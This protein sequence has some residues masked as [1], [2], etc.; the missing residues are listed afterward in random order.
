MKKRILSIALIGIMVFA[1]TACSTELGKWRIT[2][3]TAGDINMTQEDI[4][5]MGL[6]PG[7]VK[8]NKSGSCVVNLLGDE[9]EGTWELK[10]DGS[11]SIKYG[12]DLEGSATIEDGV[13]TMTDAQ[14]AVYTLSR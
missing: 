5:D 13:M 6:D 14:G 9:Y 1:L 2:E 4:D 12:T 11:Y 7:F 10:E 8:I 3:V